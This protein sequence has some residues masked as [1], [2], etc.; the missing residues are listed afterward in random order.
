LFQAADSVDRGNALKAALELREAAN[1]FLQALCQAHECTLK[2][3]D[4]CP[5]GMIV[6]LHKGKHID[7]GAYRWLREIV[8]V[9]N[10]CAHCRKVDASLVKA[11]IG[12]LHLMLD[13][14]PEIKEAGLRG[15]QAKWGWQCDDDD[16]GDDAWIGGAI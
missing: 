14:A 3:Y 1:R 5:G 2:K 11:G 8:E 16:E 15:E 4:R 6:A 7:R 9:G 13:G 10:K 12:M